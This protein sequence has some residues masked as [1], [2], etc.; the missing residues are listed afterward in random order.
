MSEMARQDRHAEAKRH[1]NYA[2]GKAYEDLGDYGQAM[3]RY[4]EAN[5]WSAIVELNGR[6]YPREAQRAMVDEF[7]AGF[8]PEFLQAE[9]GIAT[10]DGRPI[11]VVGM[12]R[13]GTTLVE[14]ILSSHRQIAAGGEISVL[15][16]R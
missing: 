15:D 1:L 7:I 12:M 16:S 8:T 6:R 4:D 3:A 5:K 9:H 14:Q 13:S 2:L 11:F 10:D